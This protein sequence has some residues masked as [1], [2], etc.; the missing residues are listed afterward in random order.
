M[1][2]WT[3]D[4]MWYGEIAERIEPAARLTTKDGPGWR[5]LWGLGVALTLGIFAVAMPLKRFLGDFGTTV[6]CWLGFPRA[7]ASIAP[8]F[9]RHECRHV[10]QFTWFGWAVPVLG[11]FFGRTVRAVAGVLPMGIVY[12]LLPLPAG[13]ALGRYLLEAD[14]EET[15]WRAGM[16][17]GSLDGAEVRRRADVF[18]AMLAGREYLYAWPWAVRGLRRRAERVLREVVR[19]G[20]IG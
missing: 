5:L 2:S 15:S 9:L 3:E 18:G 12:A 20:S 19:S 17:D 11:W 16:R 13:L 14:A 10:T 7:L 4:P 6:G 1:S 8:R